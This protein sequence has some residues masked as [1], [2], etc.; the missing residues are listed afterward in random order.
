M[1]ILVRARTFSHQAH[2]A[3]GQKRKYT[4][5]PYWVHTDAVAKLTMD[6]FL[7]TDGTFDGN[8][9][10]ADTA[11]AAAYLHDVLEDVAPTLPETFGLARIID[12]FGP[13]VA[14]LVVELTHIYTKEA[15]PKLKRA[16]RKRLEAER[17]GTISDDGQTIKLLDFVDN[18]KSIVAEDPEFAK[19]YLAEKKE[20]LT[21]LTRGHPKAFAMAKESLRKGLEQITGLIHP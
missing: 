2:D 19:V 21:F 20:A 12:H 11:I 14:K 9:K 17:L 13:E 15:Y 8:F 3:I 7:P 10:R 16:E 6:I 18:T 1:N 4:G 5:E